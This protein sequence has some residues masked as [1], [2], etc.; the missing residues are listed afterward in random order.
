MKVV[1][2]RQAARRLALARRCWALAHRAACEAQD[3]DPGAFAVVFDPKHR[4]TKRLGRAYR[5]YVEYA[6]VFPGVARARNPA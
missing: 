3:V 6:K 2:I 4:T 5:R 1:T